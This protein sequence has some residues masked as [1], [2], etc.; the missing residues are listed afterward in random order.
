MRADRKLPSYRHPPVNE[1]VLSTMFDKPEHLNAA[2]LGEFWSRYLRTELPE[3]EEQPPYS[4]P[5]EIIGDVFTPQPMNFQLMGRP[6]S[7]R[8][9]AK[10]PDGTRLVQLQ[11]DWFAF[12]WRDVG[13]TD[14]VYLRWPVVEGEFLRHFGAFREFVA[15]EGIGELPIRQCEVTYINQIVPTPGVWASHGQMGEVTTL[16]GESGDFLPEAESTQLNTSYRMV[17]ED[18]VVRGRMHVSVQPAFRVEDQQPTIV[19]TLIA[20]GAPAD[21]SEDAVV[22]LLRLG[23]EWIVEG[24]TAITT[25]AM[26]DVWELQK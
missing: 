21:S 18:G 20:R 14:Q 9:W 23:H 7:P 25:T 19:I 16:V 13:E 12:N 5:V 24:F 26:H 11:P 15:E 1:V 4:R 6:P 17:D 8:I 10:N 3:V 2:R 22:D